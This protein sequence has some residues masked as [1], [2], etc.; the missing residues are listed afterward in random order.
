MNIDNLDA[1]IDFY[2]DEIYLSLEGYSLSEPMNVFQNLVSD[3][4]EW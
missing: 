1:L 3:L 4:L 2:D